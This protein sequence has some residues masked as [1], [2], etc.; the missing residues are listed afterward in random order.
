M[1]Y[2]II[3]SL[4]ISCIQGKTPYKDRYNTPIK[5]QRVLNALTAEML[6]GGHPACGGKPITTAWGVWKDYNYEN[7]GENQTIIM[8]NRKFGGS[9]S[10][11]NQ[12]PSII[13]LSI[14]EAV[15]YDTTISEK[16]EKIR[17]YTFWGYCYGFQYKLVRGKTS[18]TNEYEYGF[19]EKTEITLEP[20]TGTM[21]FVSIG[22]NDSNCLLKLMFRSSLK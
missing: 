18:D 6:V 7:L 21:N 1:K 15:T 20:F 4:F 12:R 9:K 16:C 17:F 5:D 8:E 19:K 13:T 11:F 3:L 2:V 22:T 14:I 10:Y